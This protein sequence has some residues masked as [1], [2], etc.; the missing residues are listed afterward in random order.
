MGLL[1]GG[2][3]TSSA[4][5][6]AHASSMTT[7]CT[8]S[9]LRGQVKAS[10]AASDNDVRA[11]DASLRQ[12][13]AVWGTL[14]HNEFRSSDAEPRD[15]PVPQPDPGNETVLDGLYEYVPETGYSRGALPGSATH[16]RR[17]LQV[18]A[19]TVCTVAWTNYTG[20]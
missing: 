18:G 14:C 3:D 11:T 8:T 7:P 9:R 13:Q 6:A 16:I 12:P 4:D 20:K 19:E 17:Q 2:F 1:S 10:R 15:M 5:L